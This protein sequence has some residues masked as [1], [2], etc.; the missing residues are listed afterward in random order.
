MNKQWGII[1]LCQKAGALVSGEFATMEAIKSGKAYLVLLASDASANTKKKF[2]DKA[3]YREIPVLEIGSSEE[4]GKAIGKGFRTS[5]AVI[6]PGF[7]QSIRRKM[8]EIV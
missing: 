4:L 3:N 2:T 8:E 1:A 5:A 7:A 6:E